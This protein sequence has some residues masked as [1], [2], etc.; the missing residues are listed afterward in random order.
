MP[1]QALASYLLGLEPFR[2]ED[3]AFFCGRDGA[4]RD[5]VASVQ[6]H[7]FVAVVGPSGSGKSS[8]VFAGLLTALRKQGGTWK[9]VHEHTSEP[10]Q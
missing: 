1:R 10:L 9:I 5:L 2:E 7:R 3:A 6:E 4:I 8:L